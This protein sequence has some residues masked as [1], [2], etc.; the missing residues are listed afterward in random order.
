MKGGEWEEVP[1]LDGVTIYSYIRKVDIASSN[2]YIISFCDA[3]VFID[4]GG[5]PEQAATLLREIELQRARKDRPVLIFLTHV[6]LDHC[7]SLLTD[8]GFRNLPRQILFV[9]DSGANSLECGDRKATIADLVELD[10]EKT[11]VD[12]HLFCGDETESGIII[13][14]TP[15]GEIEFSAPDRDC[16]KNIPSETIRLENGDEIEVYHT[17]GHSPDSI[18]IRVGEVLFCGDLVFATAPGIAG[19][20]G[21]DRKELDTTIQRVLSLLSEEKITVCLPG[22]G[23]PMDTASTV[24]ALLAI[25]K[26]AQGLDGI[27]EVN[28][29]WARKT[30]LFGRSLMSEVDRLFTIIAGR[31]VYVSHV[32]EELE[33]RG[34]AARMEDLIDSGLVDELLSDFNRFSSDLQAGNKREIHLA[35]KAGQIAAKLKRLFRKDLLATVLDL[36][37]LRRIERHLEDYNVTFRGFCP[38]ARIECTDIA[39][40]MGEIVANVVRPPYHDEDIILAPDEESFARALALRIAW[41]NLFE[42]MKF[43]YSPGLS[44]PLVLMDNER[45]EDTVIFILEKLSVAGVPSINISS[46]VDKDGVTMSLEGVAGGRVPLDRQAELFARNST[47]LSGGGFSLRSSEDEF[48]IELTYP[49]GETGSMNNADAGKVSEK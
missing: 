35:L 32:L 33:E 39:I 28:P 12:V 2:S 49:V 37:L 44:L 13:D 46:R 21:W 6:H 19:L 8:P 25:Q 47:D 4:P 15:D 29:E 1:G 3:I 43:E 24:S 30:A 14:V 10:Y 11:D 22:H 42:K 7:L 27:H 48:C 41:V 9:Q 5:L 23:R 20:T 45:F 18:C 40:S 31:L 34:E 17:P 38:L 36:S 16:R 26:E